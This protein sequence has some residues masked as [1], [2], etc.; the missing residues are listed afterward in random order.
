MAISQPPFEIQL[1]PTTR[2]E[3]MVKEK[4]I[5]SAIHNAKIAGRGAAASL[6][7]VRIRRIMK[8]L[9]PNQNPKVSL[10]KSLTLTITLKNS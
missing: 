1:D 10:I 8:I 2:F 3:G 4:N 5:H 9:T 7:V 6:S